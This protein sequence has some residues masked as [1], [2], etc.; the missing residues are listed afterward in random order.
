VV[1]VVVV[2]ELEVVDVEVEVVD[3]ID[4]DETNKVLQFV[5]FINFNI[6]TVPL[7]RQPSNVFI[8]LPL[9]IVTIPFTF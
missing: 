1:D 4:V 8:R 5:P 7:Y 3:V 6:L 2:V 9:F